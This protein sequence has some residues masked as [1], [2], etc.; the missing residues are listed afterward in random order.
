MK[1]RTVEIPDDTIETTSSFNFPW[2]MTELANVPNL[3]ALVA[4]IWSELSP[5]ERM[6]AIRTLGEATVGLMRQGEALL[7]RM[8]VPTGDDT[9]KEDELPSRFST[10]VFTC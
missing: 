1:K 3:A 10:E 4:G 7:H 8:G 9:D 5:M 6:Q 2:L